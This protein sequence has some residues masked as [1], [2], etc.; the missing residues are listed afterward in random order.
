MKTVFTSVVLA[1]VGAANAI[2]QLTNS[3]YS[4]IE[5]GKTFK[6]TWSGN[7]GPVTLTLKDGPKG[8]LQDVQVL[9]T[10]GSGGSFVW[11]VDTALP[12]GDYAIEIKD[13]D[14]VNYSPQFPVTGGVDAT[15]STSATVSTVT[16]TVTSASETTTSESSTSSEE[17]S[18]ITSTATITETSSSETSATKTSTS[19][20]TTTTEPAETTT[21]PR[22]N[23]YSAAA[24]I[25]PGILAALGAAFL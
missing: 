6:I 20:S 2:V 4:D 13:G 11:A 8:N 17:S 25:V 15:T 7:E 1:I 9:T 14:D 22:S 18:T 16:S 24:P 10:G 3:D 5:A 12:N 21:P 19:T 23:A